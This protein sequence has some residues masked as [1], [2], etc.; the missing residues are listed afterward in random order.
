MDHCQSG[1]PDTRTGARQDGD[2]KRSIPTCDTRRPWPLL[3]HQADVH[4]HVAIN[5]DDPLAHVR[6]FVAQLDAR[7]QPEGCRRP[8][9]S[10]WAAQSLVVNLSQFLRTCPSR[11]LVRPVRPPQPPSGGD[12]VGQI[13]RASCSTG[14]GFCKRQIDDL[15]REA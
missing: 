7:L 15:V 5:D 2:R 13:C 11:R 8:S 14:H 6:V 9:T 3:V 10:C 1:Q 12:T 4:V